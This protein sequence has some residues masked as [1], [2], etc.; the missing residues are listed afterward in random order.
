MT[1][2]KSEAPSISK[3][4]TWTKTRAEWW[5]W[6]GGWSD[7][8]EKL[9]AHYR[10]DDELPPIV[11]DPSIPR[12]SLNDCFVNLALIAQI[13]HEKRESVLLIG[14]MATEAALQRGDIYQ[15]LLRQDK[16]TKVIS[17]L[18]D[19]ADLT[20]RTD[21]GWVFIRGRA[22]TGKSTLVQYI[23][24]RWGL[25]ESL[26]NNR[27]E[28]MFRVKLNLV[29]QAHFWEGCV[30]HE[31]VD[32]LSW[33]IYKSLGSPTKPLT[34][35]NIRACLRDYPQQVLILLDG[36]DEVAESYRTDIK[37]TALIDAA[38]RFPNGILTSRPL[39]QTSFPQP[40]LPKLQ[41]F[42]N[43][44]LKEQHVKHYVEKYFQKVNRAAIGQLL[45]TQLASN[46]EM[47]SLAH[48]PVNIAAMCLVWEEEQSPISTMTDLYQRVVIWLARRYDKNFKLSVEEQRQGINPA[49][50]PTTQVLER[51]KEEFQ[52]LSELA[53]DA[54]VHNEIQTLSHARLREH[55][56]NQESLHK[57]TQKFGILRRETHPKTRG[58]YAKHYFIHLTYQEYFTALYIAQQLSTK[59]AQNRGQES[60][61]RQSI[62]D[63]KQFI[64]DNR[65]KSHCAVVW[66]FLAGILSTTPEYAEG[67]RYFWDIFIDINP[68]SNLDLGWI[69]LHPQISALQQTQRVL[70]EALL[71]HRVHRPGFELSQRLN[72][73]QNRVYDILYWHHTC[74]SKPLLALWDYED[75]AVNEST[76]KARQQYQ[77]HQ[78]Q[79]QH[80]SISL[81]V[82]IAKPLF[83][84]SLPLQIIPSWASCI[85]TERA[86]LAN[87]N[88]DV[89]RTAAY[90]LAQLG[91]VDEVTLNAL[92][93]VLK[94]G[95]EYVRIAA[96]RALGELGTVDEV[97]LNALRAVLKNRYEIIRRAAARA[98]GQLGAVDEVTLNPLRA[99][100]KDGDEDV[101]HAA[102]SALVQL[103]A[104]DEV[105]L[106]ALR[107]VLKD[108]N[109]YVR[110]AAAR[111]LGQPGA[112]DEVT[113]NA[114]RAVLKD[115]DWYVRIAAARALGQLG[116]V[117]EV[118]LNVLRAVLKDGDKYVRR[119][120]A[121]ALGQLGA[122][123]EVTLNA[124]RAVL[125]DGDWDVRAAA[126][127]ALGQLGAVDEVTLNVLRA[128][129]KDGYEHV[130]CD[131]ARALGQ[132]GAVD[133]ATLNALRAALKDGD[134]YLRAAAASALGQLGAVDEV[135][136]NA[137]RAVL[138][139]GYENVRGAAARVL[140]QLGA[141]DEVT[142]NALRAVLKDGNGS[143][144]IDAAR[145]LKHLSPG[146]H[147]IPTLRALLEKAND[148]GESDIRV[149]YETYLGLIRV[150][151]NVY[152][153]LP[154][155][156]TDA[157]VQACFILS[158]WL[159]S[160]HVMLDKN[161]KKITISGESIDFT[162]ESE[163]FS[164]FVARLEATQAAFIRATK[165][166]SIELPG[167][168]QS[169]TEP[170]D[171]PIITDIFN[172]EF[173]SKDLPIEETVLHES[174]LQAV[175][176]KTNELSERVE[177]LSISNTTNT[178][179]IFHIKKTTAKHSD[180]IETLQ[181]E[182]N[183]SITDVIQFGITAVGAKEARKIEHG[184][185]YIQGVNLS[186]Q[187]K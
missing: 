92:R 44:G 27:F 7:F 87:S 16:A 65:E 60:A 53:Y 63:I 175:E 138:K 156:F 122:V 174:R 59:P 181:E 116:A 13:E 74:Q 76:K 115:G 147:D 22:G 82:A 10:A 173:M 30:G 148:T 185:T 89:R 85:D 97:T 151:S 98:L 182:R 88:P 117:D 105:T 110:A 91:A 119:A 164:A 179:T 83:L 132:L 51:N 77:Q 109:K 154:E 71:T 163:D 78:K 149:L 86:G 36:F 121:R 54:F 9:R 80:D 169:L 41:Y 161:N 155:L 84:S 43:L 57:I 66:V 52:A 81:G 3:T 159:H 19:K 177:E 178:E 144:R 129:L 18:F 32:Y 69:G 48:I 108:G 101:R 171:L 106:N 143:V 24:H 126:A 103:G 2:Q 1:S 70:R 15:N 99:A 40:H 176:S 104:V 166:S 50:M 184:Q 96:A 145:A 134:K 42:E 180:A 95:D 128:A 23:S 64:L 112:V 21:T 113:L 142:L 28:F 135:T 136:L 62:Q 79:Y 56:P 38:M 125:K 11:E 93:A 68:W 20:N 6:A 146:L 130:R 46:P 31:G 167:I 153:Q 162:G 25:S 141:V 61:R 186:C 58:E 100:L 49:T 137:L 5:I 165:T 39:P 12:A 29:G 158:I 139:D 73:L 94:D 107:A 160:S 34:L 17:D 14:D 150:P 123:D 114:L 152:A 35:K 133:E 118:T 157:T 75:N 124:L 37:L 127:R 72:I 187:Q 131:A 140:G 172:P 55:F 45:W 120:A 183:P 102:A 47:M 170:I 111:A 90:T 67:A 4:K 168:L 26:W 33:L 8:I